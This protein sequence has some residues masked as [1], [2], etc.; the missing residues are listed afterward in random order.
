M[1]DF[2]ELNPQGE[3]KYSVI[4]LHGL[5]ADATD[6]V[7]LV[8]QLDLPEGSGIKFIFPNAP[9]Q[10]VTINGGIEMTAWYDILSLD[11]MGAGSDRKGI[12]K[13]QALIT[14]L[15][16]REIEAGVEPEKIFLAGFSQGCVMAL[17][18]ALRYPKK[19]AGIIGLSG[20]IALSESLETEAHKNN[21]DIP[22]FLA[23]GT[24]DDIVNISFAEDSKKLLESLGYKVQWHTYPMGH[25]VCLPEIKDIK[26]FILNNL[27]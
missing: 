20:Y 12:E 6:F 1:N 17:H 25:E 11:R 14:S 9:T 5:G 7:P 10:P 26:E 4:W 27:E 8:P 13:S 24:R 21:K 18:T 2:I 22:I 15:I 23:H 16:E 19:L 3:T